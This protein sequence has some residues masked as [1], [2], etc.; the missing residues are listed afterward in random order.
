MT[1]IQ[2]SKANAR[3][4]GTRRFRPDP[5]AAGALVITAIVALPVLT[6]LGAAFFPTE[7]IWPHLWETVL[8]GYIFSTL[9]L[10]AGVATGTILIGV[11]AAWLVTAC[12]FPGRRIFEWALV[13]PLAMPAY[14]V[15]YVYTDILEFAGPV[16]G[17][18]RDIFGW[19]TVQDYWFPE[20]R[21]LGG[22]IV[23]M[24]M[25]LYP[26]VYLLTRSAFLEQS[27]GVG[28]AARTLGCSPWAAF[29]RVSLPMA[30]PSIVVGV[31]LVLMETLNDFG[32]VD[33]FA[34]Q[35]LTTG[36]FNVWLV[37]N[38]TGGGAQIAVVMLVF[39]IFLLV[40][41]RAA[42]RK[43]GYHDTST[44]P[45]LP[46]RFELRGGR[47][48]LALLVCAVPILIGFV[49]PAGLLTSYA[50]EFYDVSLNNRFPQAAF[51]SILLAALAAAI[52]VMI[53]LFLAYAVRLRK[54]TLLRNLA[55][56]ASL[57]YAVP[58]AVL[59]IG[60]LFPFGAFDN[61]VD[62]FMRGAFGISTGLILSG[63]IIAILFAYVVR[64]LALAY[65]TLEAGLGRVTPHMD[66]AARTLKHGPAQALI[67]VNL[68]IIRGSMMTAGI[69]IFV[70]CMKELP[71]TLLLRP[72]N[73]RH[74]GDLCLS[75]CI[76]R[77]AG[78][79]RTRRAHHRRRRDYSCDP[80]DP[81]N[82]PQQAGSGIIRR[83]TRRYQAAFSSSAGGAATSTNGADSSAGGT[84]S[85]ACVFSLPATC[86]S[87]ALVSIS[88][89]TIFS[90][91]FTSIRNL[92]KS[93]E[94]DSI[95]SLS[96][97]AV[98]PKLSATLSVSLAAAFTS[99]ILAV[100][101]WV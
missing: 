51:N 1:G 57:G 96:A 97:F 79:M 82:G 73:F 7:N 11:S 21:S 6:V 70:D 46:V 49:I 5:W 66:D 40:A 43:R 28:E 8:P 65:G 22:A 86:L 63:T 100:T 53:G 60:I 56:F 87:P 20:I 16:Q 58:G 17:L 89:R 85:S 98:V 37:M 42:R 74:A 25:T 47:K 50:I 14:V 29:R 18:L 3:T 13:L 34:V 84:E 93:S 62:S 55:R 12:D 99:A 95:S 94:A 83:L 10:M 32:T 24:T 78:G 35:T 64:F 69:L 81:R 39:V 19:R 23:V 31:A 27:S 26:Y 54:S 72:F 61:A 77:I 71:A 90:K 45:R 80:A 76:R 15:A 4:R 48:A 2:A 91:E 36:M 88:P 38:N 92:W 33:F 101:C 59:A 52:A 41:E 9:E 68:P 44:R 30:R 67:K 75:V